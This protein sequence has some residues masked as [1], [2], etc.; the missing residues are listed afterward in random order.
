MDGERKTQIDEV[1]RL[2]GVQFQNKRL[3]DHALTH[4]SFVHETGGENVSDYER[5]E[6]LGDAVLE[7]ALSHLLMER[8]TRLNA[9]DLSKIRAA[10]V[11]KKSLALL[12]RDLGLGRYIRL[13]RGETLTAGREKNS[14]LSDVFESVIGAMYLDLGFEAALQFVKEQFRDLFKGRTDRILTFDYKTRLQ[15]LT[16]AEYRTAPTYKLVSA[17]GPDHDKQFEVELS[18]AG[19][20]V[21]SGQGR[22]KKD[23][24]QTAAQQAF[25][26]LS[27]ADPALESSLAGEE[28]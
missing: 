19:R 26:T 14:I 20:S 21:A 4:R 5:L 13:S 18:I 17:T 23:A 25:I 3:L 15:E 10:A 1:C 8:F 28:H 16:Q 9:G 6:F 11:N 24:E 7:L 12:A 2:L 22:T 27:G